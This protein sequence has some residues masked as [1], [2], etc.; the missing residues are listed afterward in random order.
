MATK[1]I[2]DLTV[3]TALA[4]A[5]MFEIAQGGASKSITGLLMKAYAQGDLLAA[6]TAAEV[7]VTAATTLTGT[8]FGRMHV[9]SG[10]SADY[11]VGLPAA[12][13]NTGKIIGLRMAVGLTKLVTI[14]ANAS[15]LIDGSLTRVM[16]AGESAIL[17]CDGTGWVKLFGNSIPM[18]YS[19]ERAVAVTMPI[20]TNTAVPMDT[21]IAAEPAAVNNGS[22]LFVCKR[23]G[24]YILDCFMSYEISGSFAGLEAYSIIYVNG[25]QAVS[26]S[27]SAVVPTSTA[28]GSTY[29]HVQ[30]SPGRKL[31]LNDT[32]GAWARHAVS[33]TV[34]TRTPTVVR[35]HLTVTEVCNW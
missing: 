27:A 22:G 16:W 32:I 24:K 6:L 13:G 12:S 34:G 10:T 33:G 5:D 17:M 15:E 35:P 18:F 4:D 2:S 21:I 23:P 9:C 25:A 29:A 30:Q 26:P 8:A 28:S 1:K 3:A 20:T 7:S 31:A 11:T 14:D 19:G